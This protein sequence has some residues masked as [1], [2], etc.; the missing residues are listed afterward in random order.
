MLNSVRD[1]PA[2]RTRPEYDPAT[3]VATAEFHLRLIADLQRQLDDA[4]RRADAYMVA[5]ETG[6][7]SVKWVENGVMH[8]VG[9][10]V[11]T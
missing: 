6:A 4:R 2:Q 9:T 8:E 5:W 3:L 1:F 11:R 10:Y 7:D